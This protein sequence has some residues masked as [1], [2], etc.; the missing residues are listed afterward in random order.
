MLARLSSTM[1]AD[2]L[3]LLRRVLERDRHLERRRRR[4]VARRA[5][6]RL[7]RLEHLRLA[8]GRAEHRVRRERDAPVVEAAAPA[9]RLRSSS[10]ASSCSSP[11]SSSSTA[12]A[13][14]T[15]SATRSASAASAVVVWN[16]AP[17]RASRCALLVAH[18]RRAL[19]AAAQR[20]A[21]LVARHRRVDGHHAALD[22]RD[23]RL[24]L[25]RPA[26]RRRTTRR[27]ARSAG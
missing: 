1:P 12:N 16:V 8:D 4:H 14:R 17:G 2:T 20:A 10:P 11:R 15:G 22:R 21:A 9:H 25:L 24:P 26:L 18:G 5:A 13:S 3:S 23:A 27:T 19:Q 7:V 6:R